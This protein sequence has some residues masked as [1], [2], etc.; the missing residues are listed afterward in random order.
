MSTVATAE[1]RFLVSTAYP[2]NKHLH[3]GAIGF[4]WQSSVEE[5]AKSDSKTLSQGCH[6][7]RIKKTMTEGTLIRW[8]FHPRKVVLFLHTKFFPFHLPLVA[9][10]TK[11]NHW[12]HT[13][14]ATK[15]YHTASK[16]HH[17]IAWNRTSGPHGAPDVA[18][19]CLSTTEAEFLSKSMSRVTATVLGAEAEHWCL[20]SLKLAKKLDFFIHFYSYFPLVVS[21]IPIVCSKNPPRKLG[22]LCGSWWRISRWKLKQGNVGPFWDQMA[23]ARAPWLRHCYNDGSLGGFQ[24]SRVDLVTFYCVCFVFSN[25]LSMCTMD[26]QILWLWY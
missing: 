16:C 3:Q 11:D 14:G 6:E 9:A 8:L 1:L 20:V 24:F 12:T 21:D 23:R 15:L 5:H 17:G 2:S 25:M 19:C 7:S 22:H 26:S 10:K 18:D 13:S 4:C